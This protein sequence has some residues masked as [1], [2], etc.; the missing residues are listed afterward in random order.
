[1]R[2]LAVKNLPIQK[3]KQ[4][5]QIWWQDILRCKIFQ[6]SYSMAYVSLLSLVPSLSALFAV[7]T[8]FSPLLEQDSDFITKIRQF[9][10]EHLATGSGE[11]MTA[12]LASFIGNL[13]IRKIGLTGFAGTLITLVMLLRQI[14]IALNS[15]FQVHKPRNLVTR[16]VNF[17]TFTTL[18]AFSLALFL[19]TISDYRSGEFNEIWAMISNW[20]NK[21][22]MVLL[23]SLIYKLIPNCNVK[24]RPA[25]MGGIFATI[26][27]TL[28]GKLFQAYIVL[29]SNYHAIYGAALAAIPTFLLWL[30][31]IWAIVLLGALVTWRSQQGFQ[32]E[33][34]RESS[35]HQHSLPVTNEVKYFLPAILML[36]CYDDFMENN[37]QG[38]SSDELAKA[39]EL[40]LYWVDEALETLEDAGMILR[41][42]DHAG[43][44]QAHIKIPPEN[45]TLANFD[46]RLYAQ[47]N[48]TTS[49]DYRK[50]KEKIISLRSTPQKSIKP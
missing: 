37:G 27:L 34:N 4:Y 33:L 29:F 2:V 30:Y 49:Q 10:L 50:L 36:K 22:I 43:C 45:F 35:S 48:Y 25:V 24:V 47:T 19:G 20:F 13:D 40:P 23:F 8:L 9:I 3:I 28:A 31:I 1:M 15:I 6:Y 32:M 42:E 21:F 14:E 16:F 5:L 7:L 41:C 39:L 11:Q 18:G 12:Y 44:L 17:W 26:L 38:C 46:N